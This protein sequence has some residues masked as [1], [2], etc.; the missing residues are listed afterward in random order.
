MRPD[1]TLGLE[2]P[3]S[4]QEPSPSPEP[5]PH[6]LL[7]APLCCFAERRVGEVGGREQRG[8]ECWCA[9]TR[10]QS[11]WIPNYRGKGGSLL[12]V[13]RVSLFP[14]LGGLEEAGTSP[15]TWEV[16]HLISWV[17]WGF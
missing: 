4:L 8:S 11:F 3:M 6:L 16:L 9:V 7:V 1:R 2:L 15:H 17:F 10:T 5:A 14:L 12:S 13:H